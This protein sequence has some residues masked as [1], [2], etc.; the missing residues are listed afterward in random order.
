VLILVSAAACRGGAAQAP[1]FD[2]ELALRRVEHMVAAGARVPNTAA[3]RAIG[4]WIVQELR[5]RADSV[6]EQP[7]SY[8]TQRGDTLRLRNILAR[9]RPQA[10]ERV[11]FVSHWDSRP[12]ADQEQ[13]PARRALPVPG[14]DDGG[15]STA[16]LLGV[17]DALR[18]EPPAVGVDLLFVDGEDWGDFDGPDVLI[19]STYFAQHLPPGYRPLFG[20]LF[21]I[22]GGRDVVFAQEGYSLDRAPEVVERV[23]DAARAIGLGRMFRN[24]GGGYVKDDHVPLL[25]AGLRVIDVIASPLPP[26]WHTVDD[27]PDKL[28]ARS[29]AAVGSL[30][31]HLVR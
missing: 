1:H 24:T 9:F 27:T 8:V 5:T 17:A 31:V 13:D 23:W 10:T 6:E 26:Y 2:G 20:V 16:V 11:L 19:G 4:D 25:E 29:L 18:Q 22:V 7:F 3:H 21:D 30:A 28:S 15:S 14:A 12:T